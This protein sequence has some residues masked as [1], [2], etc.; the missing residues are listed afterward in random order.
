MKRALLIIIVAFP[1]H[2]AT[3]TLDQYTGAL[4][5]IRNLIA[6]GDLNTAREIGRAHV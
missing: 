3:L 1:L 5:R 2:A 6:A 4:T